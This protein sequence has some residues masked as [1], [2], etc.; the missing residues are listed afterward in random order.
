[1]ENCDEMKK[2]FQKNKPPN[3]RQE[4]IE[5]LISNKETKS[6]IKTISPKKV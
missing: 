1:M 2:N 5:N 4:E 6:N 3:L